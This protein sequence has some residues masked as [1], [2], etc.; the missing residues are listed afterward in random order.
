MGNSTQTVMAVYELPPRA[1]V[2][3]AS[4]ARTRVLGGTLSETLLVENA[5]WFCRLR[6]GVAAILGLFGLLSWVPGLFAS[7][8]VLPRLV[9]PFGTGFVLAAANLG[10]RY[11]L[12]TL[13][14]EAPGRPVTA[15][16]WSQIAVDLTVLTAV[17]H[18]CGYTETPIYFAYLFHVVLAC[19]F[20]STL[21]SFLVTVLACLLFSL[22]GLARIRG[23][24]AAA[25]ILPWTVPPYR[26]SLAVLVV[27]LLLP[28]VFWLIV[29]FLTTHLARMVQERDLALAV[30][31]RRLEEAQGERTR[32]MLH[33]TH[34]L[35]APFAAIHANA[36]LLM[37]GYCGVLPAK[38]LDVVGRI[39]ARSRRLAWAIRDMLQ[40]ANLSSAGQEQPPPM[41]L[42]LAEILN[43]S[44]EQ[45]SPQA[46]TR[47][48]R[49]R[50][51]GQPEA[52]F[53]LL[54]EDHMRMLFDNLLANAVTYSYEGGEVTLRYAV[55]PSGEVIV[56]VA[57]Q[58]I[59]I[60]PAKL[61]HIFEEYYR[62]DEA[63]Q[64]CSES[65]G[66]GLAIVRSV[67]QSN[68]IGLRVESQ[69]GVGTTVEVRIPA[70]VEVSDRV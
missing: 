17:V 35:K 67:A 53:L 47:G 54:P 4:G 22:C 23:L 7:V 50:V 11:H 32:H 34:E 18:F 14:P 30:T 48:I 21:N 12:G 31:N 5:L 70:R 68:G 36:Q 19:I 63:V 60:H 65:T 9:W 37:Q 1:P 28:Q 3:C 39:A 45:V 20:F 33:T 57:D 40:L 58:G 66:L 56:T 25:R 44:A 27:H 42:D 62:T 52:I 49:L 55:D 29:W 13:R 16:L 61:P 46:Q 8:G 69:P 38:A 2:P 15:N 64:H 10:F 26:G 59:G 41:R 24:L 6:W 51:E 43:R